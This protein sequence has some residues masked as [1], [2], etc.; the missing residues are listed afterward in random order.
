[1]PLMSNVMPHEAKHYVSPSFTHEKLEA[2]AYQDIVDVFED[3]MLNWLIE[4]AHKLLSIKH[5]SVAAVALLFSYFEG[6]EIFCSGQDS[7]HKSKAFFRKGFARV[8]A[9]FSGPP[10]L[11]AGVSDALYELVRCGFA[12]DALFRSG[13]YF[14]TV[15]KEAFTVTWPR[16]NGVFV[17][18]GKLESVFI[19]PRRFCEGIR[20]HF[21]E[22]VR[23]LRAE[24]D[25]ELKSKFLTAIEL[26]WR[27]NEPGHFVGMSEEEFLSG[28]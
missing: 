6:I 2:P 12:H 20:L 18:D 8:F 16:K 27:L 9:S 7:N 14:S 3:R 23:T 5:G 17:E 22:Y 1:M 10:V 24:V 28:A 15:R 21:E 19:N 4:P 11:L 13:V 25:A 26:K